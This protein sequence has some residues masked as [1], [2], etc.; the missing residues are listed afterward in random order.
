MLR[1]FLPVHRDLPV[2][3]ADNIDVIEV[4]LIVLGI[5]SAED[6]HAAELLVVI[7]ANV[8]TRSPII[9][10]EWALDPH[11][12]AKTLALRRDFRGKIRAPE[13]RKG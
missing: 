3:V 13:T 12:N 9:W 1:L 11:Q 2:V 10:H 7:S 4:S 6:E 8:G 5:R